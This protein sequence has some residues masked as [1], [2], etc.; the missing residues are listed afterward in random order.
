MQTYEKSGLL[1]EKTELGSAKL[2]FVLTA[3]LQ[4]GPKNSMTSKISS[5]SRSKHNANVIRTKILPV[6]VCP[7]INSPAQS[8]ASVMKVPSN[9]CLPCLALFCSF[10]FGSFGDSSGSFR[11][12][13]N[14]NA[15]HTRTIN[16]PARNVKILDNTK[17]H[18]LRTVRQSSSGGGVASSTGQQHDMPATR[19]PH[20]T[21]VE[22]HEPGRGLL[23]HVK[24]SRA[25]PG[26]GRL[27]TAP[28]RPDRPL[29]VKC[30]DQATR[31][32]SIPARAGPQRCQPPSPKG[33]YIIYKPAAL[34]E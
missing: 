20:C 21:G 27:A 24:A 17:H 18:H 30:P 29:Q 11:Q 7:E 25:A 31:P 5:S 9:S 3:L 10:C 6:V 15:L 33:A 1:V 8:L 14:A 13:R 12:H 2:N 23:L 26:P 28:C 34:Y 4:N 32:R 16:K 22:P 19:L